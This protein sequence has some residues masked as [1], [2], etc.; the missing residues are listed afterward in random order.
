M[1]HSA[2]CRTCMH[3]LVY[4]Y[5]RIC[6]CNFRFS[7]MRPNLPSHTCRWENLVY[8]HTF[9]YVSPSQGLWFSRWANTTIHYLSFILFCSLQII[10]Q[11]LNKQLWGLENVDGPSWKRYFYLLENLAMVK[12][13]NIC[14]ELE[15]CNEIFVELFNVF[16]SIAKWVD[17]NPW[18]SYL[19]L[20]SLK[21][22]M[23]GKFYLSL[24]KSKL[25]TSYMFLITIWG[26]FLILGFNCGVN[27]E[28]SR[29]WIF[30]SGLIWRC[31]TRWATCI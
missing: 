19:F 17:E 5:F 21:K 29:I 12:S 20:W 1:T 13:Y 11:F 24:G 27:K 9:R 31:S 7:W 26:F 14:M 25:Q 23:M 2:A 8:H 4:I 10:F 18:D 6:R 30:N 15:D 22:N 28:N 3:G 16:F